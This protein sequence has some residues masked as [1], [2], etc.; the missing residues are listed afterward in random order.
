MRVF[1]VLALIVGAPLPCRMSSSADKVHELKKLSA[2]NFYSVWLQKTSGKKHKIIFEANFLTQSSLRPLVLMPHQQR[3]AGNDGA[4][5]CVP[6]QSG[7]SL[8]LFMCDHL[9]RR[10]AACSERNWALRAGQAGGWLP[11]WCIKQQAAVAAKKGSR[12]KTGPLA[13]PG[14]GWHTADYP[15]KMLKSCVGKHIVGSDCVNVDVRLIAGLALRVTSGRLWPRLEP[16]THCLFPD[17]IPVTL[18]KKNFIFLPTV[19]CRQKN[20]TE[21]N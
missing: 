18:S 7:P 8:S 10:S 17:I 4:P 2:L 13:T 15:N 16:L 11:V 21:N 12:K 19:L 9:V 14:R 5:L 3:H 20:K 1:Q 6:P